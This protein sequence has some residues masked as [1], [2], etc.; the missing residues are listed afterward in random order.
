MRMVPVVP[1]FLQQL[2]PFSMPYL[3]NAQSVSH[4]RESNKVQIDVS[5]N[6][7]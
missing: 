2:R 6:F 7:T 3:V 5:K 1:G 4:Y